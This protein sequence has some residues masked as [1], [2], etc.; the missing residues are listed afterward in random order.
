LLFGT[1][2][3]LRIGYRLCRCNQSELAEAFHTRQLHLGKM[4]GRSKTFYRCAYAYGELID[5]GELQPL[6]AGLSGHEA[7]EEFS[8]IVA[9]RG[10][11]PQPGDDDATRHSEN[12]GRAF[13]LGD[14]LVH[15][16][17]HVLYRLE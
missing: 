13:L 12:S 3:Q 4:L 14:E 9:D 1:Q 15:R 11:D 7:A 10:D 6:D 2:F 17:R 8:R 5:K 16:V